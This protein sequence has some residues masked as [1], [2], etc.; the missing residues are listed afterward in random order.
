MNT[1][2][3]TQKEGGEVVPATFSLHGQAVNG[4][5]WII[6]F[7]KASTFNVNFSHFKGL[8]LG[9]GVLSSQRTSGLVS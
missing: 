5:L 6:T 1:E 4:S 8:Y 2:M 7:D 9:L 3:S